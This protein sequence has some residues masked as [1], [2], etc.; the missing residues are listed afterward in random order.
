MKA[1]KSQN[2]VWYRSQEDEMD[3]LIFELYPYYSEVSGKN[4]LEGSEVMTVKMKAPFHGKFQGFIK[5]FYSVL[6]W[7]QN[8]LC[9]FVKITLCSLSD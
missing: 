8:L 1:K 5:F 7:M 6:E 4:R 3:L 9:I 2:I